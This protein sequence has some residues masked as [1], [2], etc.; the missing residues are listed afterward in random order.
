MQTSI[1]PSAFYN[2]AFHRSI[3]Y[4]K[5]PAATLFLTESL[6]LELKKLKKRKSRNA[7]ILKIS[8]PLPPKEELHN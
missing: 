4:Q 6:C 5:E 8:F 3:T 2:Y 7:L 1:I